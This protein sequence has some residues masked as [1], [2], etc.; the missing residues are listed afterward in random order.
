M[1]VLGLQGSPRRKGNTHFLL[2]AFL[3]A[4]ARRGALTRTVSVNEADIQPCRELGVC[5]KRGVCPIRDDVSREIYGLIR[6]AEVVVLASPV[7]F[8]G[9]TAQIKALVD[10][11]QVFWAR[12]YRLGLADPR[13][14]TRRGF[15][16][17]LGATRGKNLFEGLLL[18]ARYFLDAIDAP[19]AGSL[20]Y[21]GIEGPGDM[22]RHGSVREEVEAAV[23]ALLAPM[24]ARKRLLFLGRENDRRSPM[25]AAFAGRRAAAAWEVLAAGLRP[26]A[27]LQ[28]GVA[29][30]MA[31]KGVDIGF[32]R[33]RSLEEA[34]AHGRPDVVVALDAEAAAVRVEGARHEFWDLPPAETEPLPRLRDALEARVDDFLGREAGPR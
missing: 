1:L 27:T 15:V 14:T 29:E 18:S 3:E 11:C 24:L 17:S 6:Q 20:L 30:A 16:L 10:R 19:L 33:P 32:E 25:A 2:S 8:Y 23:E 12:K 9:M 7:F 21:R 4:A 5:E 31:E 28:P 26:A 34:L 13:Q 22:A